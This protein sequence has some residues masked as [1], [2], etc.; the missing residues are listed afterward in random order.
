MSCGRGVCFR[1]VVDMY[2]FALTTS[3]IQQRLQAADSRH[4]A[5]SPSA[6]VKYSCVSGVSVSVTA[7]SPSGSG[8][9]VDCGAVDCGAGSLATSSTAAADGIASD[10]LA[11]SMRYESTSWRSSPASSSESLVTCGVGVDGPGSITYWRFRLYNQ[12]RPYYSRN[13]LKWKLD[14]K[15]MG[16]WNLWFSR[17]LHTGQSRVLGKTRS[18][19]FRRFKYQLGTC[20][21]NYC[22]RCR[23]G[24]GLGLSANF[25]HFFGSPTLGLGQRRQFFFAVLTGSAQIPCKNCQWLFLTAPS[26]IE[27]RLKLI[28]TGQII[29][30][31]KISLKQVKRIQLPE[32]ALVRRYTEADPTQGR[33]FKVTFKTSI[34]FCS[35]SGLK[36]GN[37]SLVQII[38]FN[39]LN[40]VLQE[41]ILGWRPRPTYCQTQKQS[42]LLPLLLIFLILLANVHK[43]LLAIY[44]FQMNIYLTLT[45]D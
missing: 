18:W 32:K 14:A 34:T 8:G 28:F 7:E 44:K 25:L 22:I 19:S 23:R 29:W 45:L 6:G 41:S 21:V 40:N 26:P 37:G 2:K 20:W 42:H 36:S 11:F 31:D 33:S 17:S 10:F 38:I 3:I 13:W 35:E 5:S 24:R 15:W 9:A 27:S 43:I 1:W 4:W 12:R 39:I 16:E 30:S